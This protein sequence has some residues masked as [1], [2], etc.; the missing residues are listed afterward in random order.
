VRRPIAWLAGGLA[1]FGFLRR[2]RPATPQA[3]AE[4]ERSDPRAE[5]LRRKLAESR[6]LVDERESFEAAEPTVDQ[7]EHAPDDPE[8]RR[9]EVHEAG[10]E[11]ARE[12]RRTAGS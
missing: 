6:A 4:D 7:T 10:R 1:L 3:S 11:I 8:R 5:E 9:R 2:R 12:M